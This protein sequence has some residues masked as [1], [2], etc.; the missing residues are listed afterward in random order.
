MLLESSMYEN[1]DKHRTLSDYARIK[2]HN[3]VAS[4]LLRPKKGFPK[5]L[6]R[7]PP[8]PKH[9]EPPCECYG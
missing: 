4:R 5:L 1:C 6:K 7:I 8:K 2:K 9:W 3:L